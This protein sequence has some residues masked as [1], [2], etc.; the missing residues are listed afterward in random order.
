MLKPAIM[1]KDQLQKKFSEVI[2]SDEYY[3]YVGYPHANTLPE[4]DSIENCYRWAIVKNNSENK[5]DENS[6]VIGYLAYRVDAFCN[7]VSSFGLFSFDPGNLQVIRDLH[8][9]MEYLYDTYHRME[10]RMIGGNHAMRGYT[11]FCENHNGTVHLLRDVTKDRQGNYV[12]EYIFEV[13]NS[14]N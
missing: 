13:I 11:K 1:Y 10:W 6:E 9:H 5:Y 14:N 2:Y 3:Y 4:F 12:D 7:S 8:D